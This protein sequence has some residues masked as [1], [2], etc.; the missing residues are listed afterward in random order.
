MKLICNISLNCPILLYILM[1]NYK[2][3]IAYRMHLI[4]LRF[5]PMDIPINIDCYRNHTEHGLGI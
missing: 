3:S 2:L 4:K 1:E 5:F